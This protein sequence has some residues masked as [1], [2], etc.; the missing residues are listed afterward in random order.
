MLVEVRLQER[1]RSSIDASR[2][3]HRKNPQVPLCPWIQQ[4]IDEKPAV[5][6]PVPWV[7]DA[8]SFQE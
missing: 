7:D 8:A 3:M 2:G 6:G 4:G 5:S 1:F